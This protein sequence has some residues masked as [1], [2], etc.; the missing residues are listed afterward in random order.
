MKY[1]KVKILICLVFI[2]ISGC[3]IN[4]TYTDPTKNVLW[5]PDNPSVSFWHPDNRKRIP[6]Q[7]SLKL[8]KDELDIM[9]YIVLERIRNAQSK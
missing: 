1:G 8:T 5:H 6:F 7:Q 9:Y 3:S 2:F 4:S